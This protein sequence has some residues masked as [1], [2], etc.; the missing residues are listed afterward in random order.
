V[1]VASA[2]AGEGEEPGRRAASQLHHGN[3]IQ[4]DLFE[5]GLLRLTLGSVVL[6]RGGLQAAR[7]RKTIVALAAEGLAFRLSPKFFRE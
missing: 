6:E 3:L 4:P 7:I 5:L 2:T 1:C